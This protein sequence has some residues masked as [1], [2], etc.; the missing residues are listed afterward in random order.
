MCLND[1]GAQFHKF[2]AYFHMCCSLFSPRLSHRDEA[3]LSQVLLKMNS[4]NAHGCEHN[5]ENGC[6]YD[7]SRAIPQGWRW[8]SQPHHRVTGDENRV[9]FVN[10][11]SKKQ[12]EQWMHIRIQ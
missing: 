10:V 1:G 12:P 4:E 6:G 9:S 8:I 7:F 5:P 11:V 3:I 2:H